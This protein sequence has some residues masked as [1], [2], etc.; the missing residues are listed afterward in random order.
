MNLPTYPLYIGDILGMIAY[1]NPFMRKLFF[2]NRTSGEWSSDEQ[3]WRRWAS[4]TGPTFTSTCK[5][6]GGQKGP[7][8]INSSFFISYHLHPF[9]SICQVSWLFLDFS[10][11]VCFWSLRQDWWTSQQPGQ[12]WSWFFPATRFARPSA[13]SSFT[14][15]GYDER[16]ADGGPQSCAGMSHDEWLSSPKIYLC[17]QCSFFV[18]EKI[19]ES[20]VFLSCLCW[21]GASHSMEMSTLLAWRAW[22]QLPGCRSVPRWNWC[23]SMRWNDQHQP[24]TSVS[25]LD[26]FGSFCYDRCCWW[27]IDQ[28]LRVSQNWWSLHRICS[29]QEKLRR[30]LC[31]WTLVQ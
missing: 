28:Q 29:S 9:A 15:G 6:P 19:C 20:V 14:A 22:A 5:L 17:W 27:W 12:G 21:V 1:Q 23:V 10:C 3:V 18:L 11:K 7:S 26:L 4:Y 31:W 30:W 2:V 13:V 16:C 25:F 24:P 8:C